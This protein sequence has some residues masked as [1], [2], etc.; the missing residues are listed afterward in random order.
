[1]LRRVS[2]HPHPIGS[3]ASS[4]VQRAIHIPKHR[5]LAL[6]RI[7]ISEREKRQ[8]LLTEIRTMCEAPCHEG[9]VDFHRAFYSPDSGQISIALE[10]MDGGSLADILKVT[11]KIPEPVLSSMF[12]KLLQD[13]KKLREALLFANACGAITVTERGAI[14]AMP[15]MNAVQDLLS[16]WGV[17]L[18][19]AENCRVF[20]GSSLQFKQSRTSH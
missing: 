4:V 5:L 18:Q 8:Q 7:N 16:C 6:K 10:Y 19:T 17:V 2:L 20:A 13:E 15:T 11:K 3:G 1:M 14:P 12:H 9:L